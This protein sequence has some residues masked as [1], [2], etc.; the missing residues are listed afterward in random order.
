MDKTAPDSPPDT[1]GVSWA[2]HSQGKSLR[3][4]DVNEFCQIVARIIIRV[5]MEEAPKGDNDRKNA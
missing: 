1:V 5:L 2:P 3:D 4:P